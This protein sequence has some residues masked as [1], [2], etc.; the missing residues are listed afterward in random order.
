MLPP[1]E[2]RV[3]SSWSTGAQ[4]RGCRVDQQTPC[5]SAN[6]G[7]NDNELATAFDRCG[8]CNQIA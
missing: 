7:A 6:L 5:F 8:G 1:Q 3:L 2:G 4:M